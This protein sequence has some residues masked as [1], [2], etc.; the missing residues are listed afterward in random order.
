MAQYKITVCDKCL[1]DDGK[2]VKA[3]HRLGIV[4]RAKLDVCQTHAVT[5]KGMSQIEADKQSAV[6]LE[7]ALKA[8]R[9]L[10]NMGEGIDQQ[11][12]AVHV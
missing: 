11:V 8:E 7:T 5:K 6:H 1:A 4:G 10:S 3:T 12:E 2:L 9:V